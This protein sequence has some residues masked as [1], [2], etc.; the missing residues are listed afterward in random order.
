MDAISRI[1]NIVIT[2]KIVM[3]KITQPNISHFP[4]SL[5]LNDNDSTFQRI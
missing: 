5:S 3:V 4:L 2:D 1:L